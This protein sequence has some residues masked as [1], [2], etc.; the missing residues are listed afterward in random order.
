MARAIA[1]VADSQAGLSGTEKGRLP[2]GS[3][4]AYLGDGSPLA[5]VALENDVRAPSKVVQDE[6][7]GGI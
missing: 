6:R 5:P 4:C 2:A 3:C 7:T 1:A